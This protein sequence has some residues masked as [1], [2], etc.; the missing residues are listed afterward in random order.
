MAAEARPGDRHVDADDGRAAH[1]QVRLLGGLELV[2]PGTHI[3]RLPSRGCLALLARL[4]L[5]PDRD[6]PREGLIELLWPGV[7]L[8]VGRNRLRQVLSTL[9]A[10]L[11]PPGHPGAIVADRLVVRAASG[12]FACD[13]YRFERAVRLRQREAAASLYRG[14]LLPGHYDEWI[15]A[16]RLR[17]AALADGLVPAGPAPAHPLLARQSPEPLSAAPAPRR[18]LPPP[19][20]RATSAAMPRLPG[21]AAACCTTAW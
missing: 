9:K 1:W 16:K 6:H 8:V 12:A 17:Q 3:Q 18:G 13:V 2:G 14:E 20:S 4:C 11:E 15:H 21:C 7:E 5:W 10:L 19:S